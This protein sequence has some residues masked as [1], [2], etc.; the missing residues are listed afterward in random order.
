MR[1]GRRG[2]TGNPEGRGSLAELVD[3]GAMEELREVRATGEQMG[4]GAEEVSM[5]RRWEAKTGDPTTRL[6]QGSWQTEGLTD[7]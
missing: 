3:W 5:W 4:P 6:G 7:E 1:E 2:T